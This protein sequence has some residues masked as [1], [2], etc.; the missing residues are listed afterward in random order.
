MLFRSLVCFPVTIVGEEIEGLKDY[1]PKPKAARLDIDFY[2]LSGKVFD[3]Y[4][5][6][7]E[8]PI[9]VTIEGTDKARIENGKL[10]TEEVEEETSFFIVAKAGDLVEKQE[11]TLYPKVDRE[12]VPPHEDVLEAK[13][14]ATSDR[15]D[16]I[17][18]LIAEMAMKVYE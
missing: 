16:F 8:T 15:Q 3:Q 17:E 11:R 9:D 12:P 14:K 10:I 13:I 6:V 5:D 1:N 7:I 2:S 18:D 4:G